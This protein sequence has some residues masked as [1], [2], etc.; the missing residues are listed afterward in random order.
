M[1]VDYINDSNSRKINQLYD[2]RH[3]VVVV[4]TDNTSVLKIKPLQQL[5]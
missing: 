2:T 4:V 3:V 5:R 1:D